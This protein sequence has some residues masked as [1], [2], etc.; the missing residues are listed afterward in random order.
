MAVLGIEC[1][2]KLRITKHQGLTRGTALRL[3]KHCSCSVTG[4][5]QRSCRAAAADPDKYLSEVRAVGLDR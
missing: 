1:P 5:T 3:S 4:F 2:T